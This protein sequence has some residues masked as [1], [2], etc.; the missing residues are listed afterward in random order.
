MKKLCAEQKQPFYGSAMDD[1]RISYK[2]WKINTVKY[3]IRTHFSVLVSIYKYICGRLI[4][5]EGLTFGKFVFEGQFVLLSA[6][7]TY[8]I[9]YE[10]YDFIMAIH[11]ISIFNLKKII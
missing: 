8:M 9:I 2:A 3:W 7:Q 4:L 5:G 6:Y 11:K 1:Q 10:I